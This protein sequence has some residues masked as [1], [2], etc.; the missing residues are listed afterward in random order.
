[1]PVK[2]IIGSK[3]EVFHGT[4]HHTTGGLQK[5]DLAKSKWG[6]IVSKKQQ[7]LGKKLAQKF[8][9]QNTKAPAF[10]KSFF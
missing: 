6:K 9:P 2:K 5:K 8:P 10:Q 7:Q 4:A 3:A 1:M